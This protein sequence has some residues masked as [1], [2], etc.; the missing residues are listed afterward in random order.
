MGN[1]EESRAGQNATTVAAKSGLGMFLYLEV[2][3]ASFSFDGVIG[4]FAITTNLFIIAIGLG[5]G[6]MFVRS[7]TIMLVEKN[8]LEEYQYLE[9]GAFYAII[10]LAIIMF[11]KT[12]I[13]VPEVI[14][15][16]IGA[17]F[18]AVAFV[19]SLVVKNL[20]PEA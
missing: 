8:T 7:L 4:A 15:G 1:N 9:H 14:T 12:F 13:H 18:I 5:I 20:A 2:L 10:A 6:A 17:G 11:L 16:L 19:H 3:D